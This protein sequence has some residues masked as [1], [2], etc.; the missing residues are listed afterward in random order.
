VATERRVRGL[1][2]TP[3]DWDRLIEL[4]DDHG[5]APLVQRSLAAVA[6]GVP[7]DA[8]AHLRDRSYAV[9]V[10]GRHLTRQLLELLQAFEAAQIPVL[11]FKGPALAAT[12]YPDP[13]VRPFD[14]L[15]LLV[16]REHARPAKR[17]LL[18]RGFRPSH[19]LDPSQSAY[20]DG[21]T[22]PAELA[23]LRSRS[24]HHFFR[25]R[26]G[27]LVDLHLAFADPYFSFSLDA[28]TAFARA[29]A[30]DV[31]GTIVRT[32]GLEDLLLVLCLN[33]AKDCWGRLGRVCDV[34]ELVR[35]HPDLEWSVAFERARSLG[36]LRMLH[37]GLLLATELLDAPVPPP[38]RGRARHD[39]GACQLA[40]EV[41][42]RL[43]GASE[44][45]THDEPAGESPPGT[46]AR[47][48]GR[49]AAIL[50]PDGL[51]WMARRVPFHLRV[52]ERTRD[53]LR[54]VLHLAITPGIADWM[55]VP[56][57]P[58]LRPTY[59]LLRPCRLLRRYGLR[60]IR[61]LIGGTTAR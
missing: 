47:S 26:D 33:G 7:P 5:V 13:S 17:L 27:V 22:G 20:A 61:Q 8:L 41:Q 9:R 32:L 16:R 24:E 42:A 53:R 60:V 54:Y 11:A 44:G 43:L 59:Y 46:T 10:R 50:D 30:V 2:A 56:L 49:L 28:P 55:A 36:A 15:D 25:C 19:P 45:W 40:A 48:S 57:P 58:F 14:D 31:G 21:L 38:A 6:D 3:L 12:C 35:R 39:P 51:G 52:R 29:E 4:A 18:A 34:A 23:Y 37:L 1:L